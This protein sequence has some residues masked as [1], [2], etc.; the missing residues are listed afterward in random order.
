MYVEFVVVRRGG[1]I[2]EYF[3]R[4]K[5]G[6]AN[7]RGTVYRTSINVFAHVKGNVGRSFYVSCRE[8][9][10]HEYDVGTCSRCAHRAILVR[11]VLVL[12]F[13]SVLWMLR[14][15]AVRILRYVV[16]SRVC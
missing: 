1:N 8:P 7:T 5:T 2:V 16:G 14:A 6:V 3:T 12:D 4:R 10:A 9:L 13:V 15:H 11:Y